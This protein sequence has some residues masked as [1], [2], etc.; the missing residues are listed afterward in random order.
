MTAFIKKRA[1][2]LYTQTVQEPII[3][4]PQK[5]KL[6]RKSTSS[7]SSGVIYINL[8]KQSKSSNEALQLLLR[9]T[10]SLQIDESDIPDILLKLREHFLKENESAVRVKIISLIGDI[11]SEAISCMKILI[12]ETINLIQNETSSKVIAQALSTLLRLGEFCE[13]TPLYCAST[14]ALASGLLNGTSALTG[15]HNPIVQKNA[16]TLLSVL[17]PISDAAQAMKLFGSFTH[18]QDARVRSAALH[19]MLKLHSRGAVLDPKLFSIATEALKDDYECVRKEALSIIVELGNTHPEHMISVPESDSELRLID[20]AFGHVCSAVCDLIVRIRVQAA[21]LL[22]TMVKVGPSFLLQTL[23]KKL[24]SNMRKKRSAHERAKEILTSGEWASGKRWGEDA[25]KEKVSAD[26]VSLIGT[27]ACGALVHGLEDEFLEV[28]NAAVDSMCILALHNSEF[29]EISLDFL[30]DMFNDEIEEVRLKAISSLS[31][32]SENIVLREDQLETILGALEDFSV[33]V[34][35][36]LHDMLGSCNLASA[37]CLQMLLEK[38][39]DTLQKYP[40]DKVST[41]GCTMRVGSRHPSFV[42]MLAPQLIQAHPFLE[43]AEPNIDDPAY[44]AILIMVLNA[45]QF[46]RPLLALFPQYITWHYDYLRDTM[47]HRVPRLIFSGGNDIERKLKANVDSEKFLKLFVEQIDAAIDNCTRENLILIL[48]RAEKDLEKLAEI[49][50]D[51]SGPAQFMNIYINA[52]LL[53]IKSLDCREVY[54]PNGPPSFIIQL[55]QKCQQLKHMFCGLSVEMSG[56]VRQLCLKACAMHLAATV[57]DDKYSALSSCQTFLTLCKDIK[58]YL[59]K[60]NLI[61][62]CLTTQI[63][64]QMAELENDSRGS[65][66]LLPGPVGRAL[67]PILQNGK[68]DKLPTP[69]AN[70]RITYAKMYKPTGHIDAT[71]Q[72]TAGL[73]ASVD[74]HADVYNIYDINSLRIFVKYPDQRTHMLLPRKGHIKPLPEHE[75]SGYRVRTT[76]LLSHGVWSESCHVNVGLCLAPQNLFVSQLTSNMPTHEGLQLCQPVQVGLAP[77]SIKRG[78]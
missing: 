70:I 13:K 18:S 65:K 60:H 35:E 77:K 49:D 23:D 8:L 2:A 38:L 62:D 28:R 3:T 26:S 17:L 32:I 39:L 57:R 7:S 61:A 74:L 50:I 24:M 45:A 67:M 20:V 66:A 47:P 58:Q 14:I 55:L 6:A 19:S 69:E 31:K 29:A 4:S 36:G 9:V 68:L 33:D 53:F 44:V 76:A 25:P 30:V 5:I 16:L 48:K 56:Y 71:I 46:S 75:G 12:D 43:Q 51:I 34:R 64:D 10:D 37:D 15:K 63:F 41:W 11:G 73:I 1:L 21:G 54:I 22:G 42:L 59:I 40:Q 78:I 27:G 52:Q 72:V